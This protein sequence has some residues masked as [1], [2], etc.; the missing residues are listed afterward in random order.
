MRADDMTTKGMNNVV[1]VQSD[2][3]FARNI[4][5]AQWSVVLILELFYYQLLGVILENWPST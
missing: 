3:W 1:D 4:H 2:K 5:L